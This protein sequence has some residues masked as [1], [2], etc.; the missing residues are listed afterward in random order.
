MR[1]WARPRP[2]AGGGGGAL[3]TRRPS[4]RRPGLH[5]GYV[6]VQNAGGA[7][8]A[9]PEADLTRLAGYPSGKLLPAGC[10][11]KPRPDPQAYT[12]RLVL[13]A[14]GLAWF[15]PPRLKVKCRQLCI[16]VSESSAG[17]FLDN[18]D[19]SCLHITC[20]FARVKCV[21]MIVKFIIMRVSQRFIV[22]YWV[23]PTSKAAR[24]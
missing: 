10:S 6:C 2:R 12:L 5:Y 18:Y 9:L 1:C 16:H 8:Q 20:I 11:V 24:C 13:F 21:Y 3:T 17:I 23:V 7:L 14:E 22:T 4:P 19:K 15:L